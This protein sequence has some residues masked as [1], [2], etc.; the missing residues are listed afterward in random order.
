[1]L[2]NPDIPYV[3]LNVA[4]ITKKYEFHV[5]SGASAPCFI[6]SRPIQESIATG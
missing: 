6:G 5:F 3:V 2:E 4:G 1:M